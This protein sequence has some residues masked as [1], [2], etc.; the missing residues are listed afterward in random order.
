MFTALGSISRKKFY[1]CMQNEQK[2]DSVGGEF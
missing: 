1:M 2:L